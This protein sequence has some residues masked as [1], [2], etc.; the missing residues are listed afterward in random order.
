MITKKTLENQSSFNSQ[1]RQLTETIPAFADILK[2]DYQS[3]KLKSIS[4]IPKLNPINNAKNL[5]EI[6]ENSVAIH[7]N[8]TKGK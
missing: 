2:F 6:T 3:N 4:N 8:A 1:D 7:N 5:N